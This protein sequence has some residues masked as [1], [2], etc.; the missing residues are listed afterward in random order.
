MGTIDVHVQSAAAPE[1]V[2]ALLADVETWPAWSPFDAAEAE[3]ETR[4]L[5]SG[6]SVVREQVTL[7]EPARR[8]AYTHVSGLPVR[9]YTGEVTLARRADGGTDVHWRATFAPLFPGTERLVEASLQPVLRAA[10][11]GLALAA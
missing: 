8:L 6:E 4:S 7:L 1:A 11:E 3:G 9:S 10:A 5:R 2:W